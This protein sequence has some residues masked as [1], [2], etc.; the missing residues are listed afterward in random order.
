MLR[1]PGN[2]TRGP[3]TTAASAMTAAARIKARCEERKS[4]FIRLDDETRSIVL[5]G[6]VFSRSALAPASLRR[7]SHARAGA[8][9]R[10]KSWS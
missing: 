10:L 6:L 8:G 9:M 7:R 4:V 2:G 1:A 5:K 3:S